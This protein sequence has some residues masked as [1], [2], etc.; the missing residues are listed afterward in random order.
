MHCRRNPPANAANVVQQ[1]VSALRR[2]LGHEQV[3]TS[4]SGYSL[5]L[6][7]DGVDAVR[8]QQ[9]ASE[10]ARRRRAGDLAGSSRLAA[11]AKALERGTVLADMPDV[12]FVRTSRASL[13]RAVLEVD[14]L[15]L[16]VGNDLGLSADVLT[17]A[18]ALAAEASSGRGRSGPV[19]PRAR[20]CWK[21]VGCA[22]GVRVDAGPSGGA[23]RPRAGGAAPICPGC[24]AAGRLGGRGGGRRTPSVGVRLPHPLTPLRGREREDSVKSRTC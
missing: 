2:Q 13:E 3:V 5:N 6:A 18:E 19:D 8:F 12:P 16:T 4:P 7:V 24:G 23:A 17:D 9:L 11:Q 15:R 21:A 22:R 1:Y 20:G 14:V 10:A